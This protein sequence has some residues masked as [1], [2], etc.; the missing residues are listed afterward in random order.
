[1]NIIGLTLLITIAFIV[2]SV[3][4]AFLVTK[5]P[6]TFGAAFILSLVLAVSYFVAL[7]ILG[8]K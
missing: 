5:Y 3:L 6:K 7:E 2:V 4:G 8:G 1:M